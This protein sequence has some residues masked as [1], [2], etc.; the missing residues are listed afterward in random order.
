MR[1]GAPRGTCPACGFVAFGDG[2]GWHRVCPLCGWRNDPLQLAHPDSSEGE[3][4]GL[5]LRQAQNRARADA[6]GAAASTAFQRDPRWRPLAPGESPRP[7]GT[8]MAS[9]VC[10][11]DPALLGD[12][13]P[14]WLSPPPTV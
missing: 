4:P 13:E 14:Y 9:A 6:T 10:Y 5:S 3:N 8:G 7:S 12:P 11:L 1:S 2:P